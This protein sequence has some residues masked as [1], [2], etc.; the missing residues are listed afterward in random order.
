MLQRAAEAT[1]E[2][3]LQR[4]LLVVLKALAGL[5][6]EALTT[7]EQVAG[8]VPHI[9]QVVDVEGDGLG[10]V[11]CAISAAYGTDELQGAAVLNGIAY[12]GEANALLLHELLEVELVLVAH[13]DDHAG[14]LGEERLD[15]VTVLTEVMQ[16]DVLAALRVGEGHLEQRGDETTGRDVVTSHDP[17]AVDELLHG[18]EG[19][20]KVLGILH[21]GHIVAHLAKALGKGR[22]A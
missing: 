20:G 15:N 21:R 16:V 9:A 1:G 22:T 5:A 7:V 19:V 3:H 6:V 11:G 18:H 8:L 17:A 14:I 4:L 10:L 13:L 12:L 2:L